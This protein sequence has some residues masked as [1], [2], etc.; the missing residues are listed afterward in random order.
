MF[1]LTDKLVI[2]LAGAPRGK[3]RPRFVRSSG[4]AFTPKKTRNYEASLQY[5]AVDQRPKGF[6]PLV[7]PLKVSVEA[8]FPVPQSWSLAKRDAALHGEWPPTIKPDADNILKLL[9]AFNQVIWVDDKQVVE[10]RIV[11]R[12]GLDPRLTVTVEAYD[13]ADGKEK[14]RRRV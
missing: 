10:A 8:V 12:Y 2:T 13:G 1:P 6:T 9:D 7:G 14:L 5:A 11:K 3:G 4:H